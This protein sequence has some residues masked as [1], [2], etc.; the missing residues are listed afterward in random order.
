[1]FGNEGFFG[2]GSVAVMR[3][4]VY[5]DVLR[6]LGRVWGCLGMKYFSMLNRWKMCQKSGVWKENGEV[7]MDV[8]AGGAAAGGEAAGGGGDGDHEDFS[9]KSPI[10]SP[11]MGPKGP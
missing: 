2:V 4:N 9:S 11:H 5:F 6:V 1:M 8:M 7:R 3:K 10:R